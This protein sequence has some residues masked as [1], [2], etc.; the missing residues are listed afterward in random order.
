MRSGAVLLT[1]LVA[2]ASA[3][4]SVSLVRI[5]QAPN[6][7]RGQPVMVQGYLSQV[8]GRPS[9][10][11]FLTEEHAESYDLASGIAVLDPTTDES[12]TQ[13]CAGARA[14]VVGTIRNLPDT[15]RFSRDVLSYAIDD[16]IRVVSFSN[17]GKGHICWQA[18]PS[19]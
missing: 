5:I 1:F 7:F 12:V 15:S 18:P 8:G 3:G 11:L 4:G 2:C 17:S 14:T 6:E 9:M 16:V 13:G 10:T 19:T